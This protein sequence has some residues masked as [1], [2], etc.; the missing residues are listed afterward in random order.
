[1]TRPHICDTAIITVL[2][3]NDCKFLVPEIFSPNGDGIQDVFHIRCI[4]QYTSANI[5]IFN[6]WGNKVYSK[7]Q[8]GNTD[9]W[10][11]TDAWWDGSSNNGG[12]VGG[13]KLTSGTYYY[14]L[15]L[16]D[17]STPRKGFIYLNR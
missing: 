6:R 17:G 12:S 13:E 5:E 1:M 3:T 14:V 7:K 8:Y 11:R 9:V 4:E 15:Q 16:N 10:G 2:V